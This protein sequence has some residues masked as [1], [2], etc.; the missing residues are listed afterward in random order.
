M[1]PPRRF[2][3]APV[4]QCSDQVQYSCWLPRTLLAHVRERRRIP[5]VLCVA[6]LRKV[7]LH[8]A[9]W[10]PGARTIATLI[11]GKT[12]LNSLMT[13]CSTSAKLAV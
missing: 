4:P 2:P 6:G 13:S 11:F 1:L 10:P 8:L 12:L 5:R 9:D 3:A 7:D